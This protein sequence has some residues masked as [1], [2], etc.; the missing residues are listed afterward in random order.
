MKKITLLCF[1]ILST[2]FSFVTTAQNQCD[3]KL[4]MIDSYGD[5][6]NGNTIDVLVDGVVVLDNVQLYGNQGGGY[7]FAVYFPVTDGSNI[8]TVWNGG[9]Y[10]PGEVSYEIYDNGDNLL[11]S[12]DSGH[13]INI[14]DSLCYVPLS[15]TASKACHTV[16]QG[17]E[18]AEC[19]ELAVNVEGG[20]GVYNVLWSTGETTHT[21]TVCPTEQ[22][23]YTV[24]VSDANTVVN[25]SFSVLVV[26]AVCSNNANNG[27]VLICHVDDEGNYSTLCVSANAVDNHLE[28]GDMLGA[29]DS[30]TCNTAPSCVATVWPENGVE[31][32]SINTEISWLG[33]TGIV[34]G[35]YLSIGTTS[36]GNDVLDN[37]DIGNVTNY[38]G[39]A[40]DY[41]TTYYVTVSPYNGNGGAEGCMEYSFTTMANPCYEATMVSCDETITGNTVGAPVNEGIICDFNNLGQSG[42]VWYTYQ[43]NDPYTKVTID[44]DGSGFDTRLGLFTGTCDA[45][46][47]VNADND[48]GSGLNS[49]LSF[50]AE[51]GELYYIYVTGDN[52]EGNY[53]LNVSCVDTAPVLVDCGTAV[54]NEYCYTDN[55]TTM[56]TYT[57]SDGLPLEV[58][59]N[60]G[61]V[62]RNWD[63]FIVL[64][65]DGVTELYNGYGD[66]GSLEGL[67]FT[68]TGDTISLMIQSDSSNSCSTNGYVSLNYDV[69]CF[70]PC[71]NESIETYCYGN[72]ENTQFSYTSDDGSPVHIDFTAGSIE[73]Y[74]DELRILDSDGTTVLFNSNSP[75][76]TNLSEVSVVSTGDT[77]TFNVSSDISVSCGS[78]Q[79]TQWEYVVSWGCPNDQT[80]ASRMA[81]TALKKKQ[82]KPLGDW[83]IYP[84]PTTDGQVTLNLSNY[85]NQSVDVKVFDTTGKIIFT[86][87]TNNVTS[88]KLEIALNKIPSGM[89]FVTLQNGGEISTKKLMVK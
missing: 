9:G 29:C 62:E 69:N 53:T 19:V 14:E 80:T 70:V 23:D 10:W 68:S 36:G 21:I 46:V 50:D 64:D 76:S 73:T 24:E 6:W 48:S 34:E 71:G 61:Y 88:T 40:F 55:D 52:S 87:T 74:Y 82:S 16:Y 47:C 12:G 49:K 1:A 86:Q 31:D 42:G 18:P 25:E 17:Y 67:T 41:S 45:L 13:Q 66:Y 28:H 56:F 84:N 89:Y 77:V 32:V 39:G 81:T 3:F 11:G 54:K 83:T 15:V 58:V 7:S 60:S 43:T 75:S 22:T 30:I 37:Q 44:T 72:Y 51:V 20:S 79:R 57:S 4:V 59:V 27:K 85:V 78:G 38:Y 65:S 63:E 33:A 26:D 35:Y 2:A 5:G 8:T